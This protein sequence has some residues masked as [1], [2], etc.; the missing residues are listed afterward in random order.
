MALVTLQGR[1]NIPYT[2]EKPSGFFAIGNRVYAFVIY[3]SYI[4]SEIIL[5]GIVKK[6]L[7]ALPVQKNNYSNGKR[8]FQR[9][10]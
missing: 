10:H 7:P 6:F 1:S 3:V 2:T 4:S 5:Q 8:H 9:T